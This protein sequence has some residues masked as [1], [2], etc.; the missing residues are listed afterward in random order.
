MNIFVDYMV[1][2]GFTFTVS[3]GLFTFLKGVNLV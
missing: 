1:L 2:L 3:S